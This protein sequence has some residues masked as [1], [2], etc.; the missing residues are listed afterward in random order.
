MKKYIVNLLIIFILI[1]FVRPADASWIVI[2]NKCQNYIAV[3]VKGLSAR[4]SECSHCYISHINKGF[5]Q[6][7]MANSCGYGGYAYVMVSVT[8]QNGNTHTSS[9]IPLKDASTFEAAML[10]IYPDFHV[11]LTYQ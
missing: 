6:G 10:T 3:S 1:A 8:E 4:R 11:E 2:E 5:Q 9:D 7:C